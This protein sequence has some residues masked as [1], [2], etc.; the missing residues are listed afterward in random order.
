MKRLSTQKKTPFAKYH[1]K[2]K[3]VKKNYLLHKYDRAKLEFICQ[4]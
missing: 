3:I 2:L 1:V 4:D